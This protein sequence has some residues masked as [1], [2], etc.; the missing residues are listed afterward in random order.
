MNQWEL[1]PPSCWPVSPLSRGLI[2]L[3]V[4]PRF[5]SRH[6]PLRSSVGYTLPRLTALGLSLLQQLRRPQFSRTLS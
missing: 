3:L 4:N 1:T 6:S 5:R 2:V